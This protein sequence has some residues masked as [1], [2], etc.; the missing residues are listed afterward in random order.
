MPTAPWSS[1]WS[2]SASPS[3]L[4]L[5]QVESRAMLSAQCSAVQCNVVQCNVFPLLQ[6]ASSMYIEE[7]GRRNVKKKYKRVKPIT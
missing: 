4:A 6:V 5:L 3:I 1:Q 2:W 7:Y